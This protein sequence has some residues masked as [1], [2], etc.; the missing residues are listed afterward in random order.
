[1]STPAVL[2]IISSAL[3]I[4]ISVSHDGN[5]D[6]MVKLIADY[7]CDIDHSSHTDALSAGTL[8]GHYEQRYCPETIN[9]VE[10]VPYDNDGGQYRYIVDLKAR[11][12]T[13]MDYTQDMKGRQIHPVDY[14][15]RA[16]RG[17]C[18][19]SVFSDIVDSLQR[20]GCMNIGLADMAD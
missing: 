1:M 15:A 19:K 17:S 13:I 11:T 9:S 12:L 4:N 2:T 7:L 8:I 10:A 20:L 5:P 16:V 3:S 14:I 6:D 18:K